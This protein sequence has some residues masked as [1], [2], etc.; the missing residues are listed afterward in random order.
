MKKVKIYFFLIFVFFVIISHPS[1]AMD[2]S[3]SGLDFDV[4][5]NEDGSVSVSEIWN[6]NLHDTNTLYKTFTKNLKS[7]KIGNVSVSELFEVQ[8]ITVM[9]NFTNSGTYNYHEQ[10]NYFHAANN[11]KGDFEIAWGVSANGYQH[12]TFKIDYTI[13]DCVNVYND[14]AEFYWQLIGN[15]WDIETHDIY[16][17]VTLP[18]EIANDEDFKVWGHGP[19]EGIIRKNGNNS[20][21]FFVNRMPTKTFLELRLVFPKSIV[22][23]STNII[24]KDKLNKILKEEQKY[25]TKEIREE[26]TNKIYG[27]ISIALFII[28]SI[29]FVVIEIIIIIRNKKDIKNLNYYKEEVDYTYYREIPNKSMDPVEASL[30]A[31]DQISDQNM[32]TSLIMSLAYKKAI[33]IKPGDKPKDTEIILSDYEDSRYT[34]YL[35]DAE[36]SLIEYFK[37]V[38]NS[39]TIK[40]LENYIDINSTFFNRLLNSIRSISNRNLNNNFYHY[41]DKNVCKYINELNSK[42]TKSLFLMMLYIYLSR[43]IAMVSQRYNFGLLFKYGFII[44][45]MLVIL[46]YII[47]AIYISKKIKGVNV[48]TKEGTEERAKWRGLKNFLKDF[49]LIDERE[50]PELVLWEQYLVYA[51]GFGIA[52]KVL[53]QLKTKFPEVSSHEYINTYSWYYIANRNIINKAVRNLIYHTTIKKIGSGLGFGHGGGFSSGGGGG[54]R[55]RPAVA[56]DNFHIS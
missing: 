56:E 31:F 10:K 9:K 27:Y 32:L 47:S 2:Q 18:S 41:K 7:K 38:G 23:Y 46:F 29:I 28:F 24:N 36:R 51:T 44:P 13:Y 15:K 4:K 39:F 3:L 8:G 33:T 22:K 11:K 53:K 50:I 16:G 37:E 49:S 48:Y 6:A 54:R 5:I 45:I 14:C 21:F 1:Y 19:L 55:R 42:S 35:T 34:T 12:R 30:L 43:T 25:A 52:N 20:C 26:K 40:Q 17:T